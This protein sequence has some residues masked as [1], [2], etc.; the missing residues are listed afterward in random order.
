MIQPKRLLVVED[1]PGLQKQFKWS[2]DRYDIMIASNRS[3]AIAAFRRHTPSVVTLDLGLPPDPTNA[4][5]GLATL[6]ELLALAPNT[7]VIVVTGNDDRKNAIEAIALG[8]YDFYQK[9]VDPDV[10][11]LIIERAFNLAN[12][13]SDFNTLQQQTS[14]SEIIA[15]SPQMQTIIRNV[16]KVA[17]T[18]AS[19]MLLGESGT[20]KEVLAKALHQLSPRANHPFIPVNCAAIPESLLE[21]E[22][23]GHEK[24]AFTGAVSQTKGKVECADKGTFFLD[25]IGDMPVALQSKLLRFIQERVIERIGG[26][27]PIAV[28]VRI[29]CATHRNL[30]ELIAQNQFRGDLYYRLSEIVIDIPPLR[31]RE[32]DIIVIAN[33][34]LQRYC[35][36]TQSKP[37]RFSL[38]AIQALEGHDWPGNIREL[39]NKLK[40][41]VIMSSGH[42]IQPEDLELTPPV[43]KTNPLNLKE[44]REVAEIRAIKRAIQFTESNISEAARLL[45]VTRPTLYNLIEKY[46]IQHSADDQ[47]E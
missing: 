20:G 37:K 33:T 28:D 41:A 29:I 23:F 40:R 34:L 3:E 22:L 14:S 12:L 16:D 10:L 30:Q 4:S 36:E 45:G 5:E 46:G 13:E 9:P 2:L 18:S 47:E 44:A 24:G 8:A 7:K 17:P 1:D 43:D 27:K 38:E 35:R 25:E 11:N 21:S 39:E 42:T 6:K 26:R 19:V 31:E 32:G 15:T